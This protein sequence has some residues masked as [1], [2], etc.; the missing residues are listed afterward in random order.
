VIA[1][2]AMMLPKFLTRGKGGEWGLAN[3]KG[4]LASRSTR[5]DRG[6]AV[7]GS[8]ICYLE[9]AY[10]ITRPHTNLHMPILEVILS[11]PQVGG[12]LGTEKHGSGLCKIPNP[13]TLPFLAVLVYTLPAQAS[14]LRPVRTIHSAA[15]T[16][17]SAPSSAPREV[18]IAEPQRSFRIA[19]KQLRIEA[20]LA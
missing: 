14:I 4:N 19:G 2:R 7:L 18:E 8:V 6:A 11:H 9:Q 16:R 10:A 1:R 20:P 3:W 5:T 15:Q 17:G 12:I 13:F